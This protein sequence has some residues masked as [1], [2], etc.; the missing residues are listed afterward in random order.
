MQ[1]ITLVVKVK[2]AQSGIS[3]GNDG[4]LKDAT[5]RATGAHTYGV[6]GGGGGVYIKGGGVFG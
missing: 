4:G 6:F 5:T 1:A 2:D 3:G